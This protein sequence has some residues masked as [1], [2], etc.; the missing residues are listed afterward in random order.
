MHRIS[1]I[2]ALASLSRAQYVPVQQDLADPQFKT[3]K[4][5]VINHFNH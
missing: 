5:R 2:L 4:P 3:T 1:L